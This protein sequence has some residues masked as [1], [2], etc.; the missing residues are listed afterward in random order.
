M[1]KIGC[2]GR[3]LHNG[4][5][6]LRGDA[7]D[8]G[9]GSEWDGRDVQLRLL[10]LV[11]PGDDVGEGNVVLQFDVGRS[12]DGL[13]TVVGF[14]RNRNDGL[15]GEFWIGFRGLCWLRVAGVEWRKVFR[16]RVINHLG[17]VE[18]WLRYDLGLECE[19]ARER[20][21]KSERKDMVDDRLE[22]AG[23]RE[24]AMHEYIRP[25]FGWAGLEFE[26]R[27]AA[28]EDQVA[29]IAE[30]DFRPGG[31]LDQ[32]PQD[33]L[34]DFD[35]RGGCGHLVYSRCRESGWDSREDIAGW[36]KDRKST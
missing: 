20:N 5:F 21:Q 28:W 11:R 9:G 13:R 15:R 29:Q 33:G 2:I 6:D 18:G 12:D 1:R 35:G 17:A 3:R 4:I 26:R 24:A 10:Q 19:E 34:V 23:P 8:L 27:Q 25:K 32:K 14:R 36:L 31:Q 7:V 22:K 16:G 30:E